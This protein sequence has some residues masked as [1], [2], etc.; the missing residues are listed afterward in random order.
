MPI[1]LSVVPVVVAVLFIMRSAE[2]GNGSAPDELLYHDRAVQ[3]L[4]VLWAA[5][6]LI[7]IY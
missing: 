6:L 5:L 1:R 2:A 4:V 7:G 3:A